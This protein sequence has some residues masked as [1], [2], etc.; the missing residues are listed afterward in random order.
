MTRH[1]HVDVIV[2]GACDGTVARSLGAGQVETAQSLT[3]EF[4]GRKSRLAALPGI[5]IVDRLPVLNA[6]LVRVD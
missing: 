2:V 1:G 6:T 4:V 5:E 3:A